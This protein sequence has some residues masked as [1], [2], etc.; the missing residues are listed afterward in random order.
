MFKAIIT[1]FECGEWGYSGFIISPGTGERSSGL[2]L[3]LGVG[4]ELP[5]RGQ[6]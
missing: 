3:E 2:H 5:V 1:T 6:S 4:S